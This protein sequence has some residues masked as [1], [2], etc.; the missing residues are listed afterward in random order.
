[1]KM[2]LATV[3]FVCASVFGATSQWTCE[4]NGH[5]AAVALD[6]AT[7]MIRI[8]NDGKTTDEGYTVKRTYLGSDFISYA[9]ASG[10]YNYEMRFNAKDRSEPELR[11]CWGCAPYACTAK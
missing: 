5:K 3:L 9:L 10:E 7:R 1:M 2:I 6:E 8:T 11:Y 4:Y